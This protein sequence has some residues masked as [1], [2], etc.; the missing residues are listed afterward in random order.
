MKKILLILCL[1]PLLV[2]SQKSYKIPA[3]STILNNI[4]SGKNELVIRNATSNITG[5]VLTNLGNGVTAFVL[6]GGSARVVDTIYKNNTKDSIVFTI[7][8]IRYAV[9]DSFNLNTDSQTLS[10]SNDTLTISGGN[11]VILPVYIQADSSTISSYEVLNSQNTPPI[12]PNTGDVYLVGNVPT[13]A[14]VGHAKDIAEW[15]GSS[16]DFTDGVQ[17]DFLYNATTVLTYI[18]RSGNWVQTTG[19]P[20]LN[21][22]NT[23]SSGLRIGTNN[24]RSLTFETNNVNRGRFDSVGRFYVYNLPTSSTSDTFVTKSDLSGKLT[25]VGE[26]TFLSGVNTDAQTLTAG[27]NTLTISGGNT[28]DLN[29]KVDTSYSFRN[30]SLDSICQ[31]VIINGN[32]TRSCIKDSTGG[33]G[34]SLSGL[35][36]ATASNTIDNAANVQEWQWNTLGAGIGLK[37]SSSSTASLSGNTLFSV[38]QTGAVA[39]GG[40]TVYAA[41]ISNTKTGLGANYGL[42]INVGGTTQGI[43]LALTTSGSGINLTSGMAQGIQMNDNMLAFSTTPHSIKYTGSYF[44]INSASSRTFFTATGTSNYWAFCTSDASNYITIN[45]VANGS[46]AL[47]F[48]GDYFGNYR[49]ELTS[50]NVI[51]TQNGSLSICGNTGLAGGFGSFTPTEI[52]TVYGTNTN[53]GIGTTTPVA[54]A[55]LDLTSTTKGLAIPTMTATQASAISTPKKSLMIYVTDTNGTFTSAG[56]WGYNGTIWKLILAE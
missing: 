19:V 5:G 21:N 53:V 23:I 40:Q 30:T 50:N 37:L 8:G 16:W 14:W 31:I 26:S 49:S 46:Y 38:N 7:S 9:K 54:S 48:G 15:N 55:I 52:L 29:R 11:S 22:G 35:T 1:F 25:K 6:G 45:R 13:G 4:G 34:S 41:K 36:A 42:D 28:V 47:V 24:A 27:V 43:C 44:H 51:R 56:W 2:F 3:D 18:F 39:T 20:A 32:P 10:I 12:S 17:G 33:G